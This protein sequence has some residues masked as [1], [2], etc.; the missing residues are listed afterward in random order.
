MSEDERGRM[1]ACDGMDD[2]VGLIELWEK[3]MSEIRARDPRARDRV[4]ASHSILN[5]LSFTRAA[6]TWI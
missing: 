1:L 4:L 6:L 2:V 5:A 3:R